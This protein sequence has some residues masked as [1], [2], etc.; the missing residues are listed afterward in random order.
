MPEHKIGSLMIFASTIEQ[1]DRFFWQHDQRKTQGFDP[2]IVQEIREKL[3]QLNFLYSEIIALQERVLD[4]LEKTLGPRRED[5]NRIL[6]FPRI[7]PPPNPD[8]LGAQGSFEFDD[9]SRLWLYVEAFYYFAHRTLVLVRQKGYSLPGISKFE[10][11]GVSRVRNNLIEHANK[12]GGVST[13][14]FSVSNAAGVRLR[15]LRKCL[16][17]AP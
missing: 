3:R 11:Y 6:V 1:L 17:R 16:K 5:E 10:A 7:Y 2:H 8:Q 9:T 14:S 13:Y 4:E 12:K 15:S